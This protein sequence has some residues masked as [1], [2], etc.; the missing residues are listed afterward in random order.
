MESQ[1]QDENCLVI[2]DSGMIIEQSK[3][4]PDKIAG[5]IKDIMNKAKSIIEND[6]TLTVQLVFD[7]M[8]AA[9]KEDHKITY[10]SW[11]KIVNKNTLQ[12]ILK[13]IIKI[14][15][16]VYKITLKKQMLVQQKD[17]YINLTN[18]L[19]LKYLWGINLLQHNYKF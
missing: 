7:N 1:S 12:I 17:E 16:H 14:I 3:Q 2:D 15:S 19:H 6:D 13:D 9:I 5:D 4:F 10:C 18:F 11:G 8:S